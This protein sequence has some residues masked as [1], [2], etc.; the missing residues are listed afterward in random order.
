MQLK[1]GKSSTVSVCFVTDS[2]EDTKDSNALVDSLRLKSAF[3]EQNIPITVYFRKLGEQDG[4]FSFNLEEPSE[5]TLLQ[6]Q[7]AL[8]RQKFEESSFKA[9]SIL[10][11]KDETI[12][13]LQKL[14]EQERLSHLTTK[15]Q[16][17][18]AHTDQNAK[19]SIPVD[20]ESTQDLI[21]ENAQLA[22]ESQQLRE[23]CLDQSEQ[24]QV[25][26]RIVLFFSTFQGNSLGSGV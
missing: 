13:N 3:F 11:Q 12:S 2:T 18:Q 24:I 6:N 14:L 19:R 26:R 5:G 23:R 4:V 10:K 21:Q 7:I 9:L 15:E 16:L 8:E 22:L 25:C 1:S 20:N 17:L